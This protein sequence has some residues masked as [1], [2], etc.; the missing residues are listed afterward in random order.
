MGAP[1]SVTKSRLNAPLNESL[2]RLNS[3]GKRMSGIEPARD[4]FTWKGVWCKLSW[5]V[6]MERPLLE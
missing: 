6:S 2:I 4:E 3:G 1:V 5:S